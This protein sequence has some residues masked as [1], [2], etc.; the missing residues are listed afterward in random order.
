[1]VSVVISA[2]QS[3]TLRTAL[4]PYR[5]PESDGSHLEPSQV[6]LCALSRSPTFCAIGKVLGGASGI[7]V[8]AKGAG[9]A[10]DGAAGGDV[11]GSVAS[12]QDRATSVMIK[13]TAPGV[14]GPNCVLK[15]LSLISSAERSSSSCSVA[16]VAHDQA[17]AVT[18][19]GQS[20][21]TDARA[22]VHR[23]GC[24]LSVPCCSRGS[25]SR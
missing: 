4:S 8:I 12:H 21:A 2:R 14:E 13:L 18:E 9:I 16:V 10:D 24:V 19:V 1:M 22:F 25:G 7:A 20:I 11:A 17:G 5:G 23:R 3:N 15:K 6:K